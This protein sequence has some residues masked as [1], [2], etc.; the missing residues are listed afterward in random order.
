MSETVTSALARNLSEVER[1]RDA[2]EE[3]FGYG[4]DISCAEDFQPD[5][6]DVDGFSTQAIGEAIYR[7]LTTPRG[8]NPDDEDYGLD[9]A[10][11]LNR[12]TTTLELRGLAERVRL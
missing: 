3:P 6:R 4:T 7:R 2:P 11:Y 8:S 9:V 5:A 1:L 10:A 12:P